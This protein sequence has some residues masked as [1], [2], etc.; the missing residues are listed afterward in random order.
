MFVH[1]SE[2]TDTETDVK[3]CIKQTR[4]QI[5]QEN[6]F[7]RVFE[8]GNNAFGTMDGELSVR[9]E[10]MDTAKSGNTTLGIAQWVL[11]F[12]KDCCREGPTSHLTTGFW[13]VLVFEACKCTPNHDVTR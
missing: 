1:I 5:W 3:A 13:A 8:Q 12:K 4:C 10:T 2:T 7:V 11:C 9:Q 6:I